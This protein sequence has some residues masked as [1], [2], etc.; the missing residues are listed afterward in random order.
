MACEIC[1]PG[2]AAIA[3]ARRETGRLA[4]AERAVGGAVAS[5]DRVIDR[6]SIRQAQV[7]PNRHEMVEGG[8]AGQ[9]S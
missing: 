7:V 8:E 9:T 3:F 6:A 2:E 5:E 1:V 4:E